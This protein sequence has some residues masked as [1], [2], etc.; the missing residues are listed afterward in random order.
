[1]F[2]R[3]S[4]GVYQFGQKK[5][6]VKVEK[7]DRILIKVG[8]GFMLIDEFIDAYTQSEIDKVERKD[9]VTRFMNKLNI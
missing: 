1:M 9:T 8:G 6:F 5:V 7:G 3:E 4:E 2:L